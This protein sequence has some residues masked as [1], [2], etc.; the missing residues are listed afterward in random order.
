MCEQ[1]KAMGVELA[2]DG[3]EVRYRPTEEKREKPRELGRALVQ[4]MKG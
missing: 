4:R 1:L 3:L 2:G